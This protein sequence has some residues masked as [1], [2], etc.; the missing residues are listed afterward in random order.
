MPPVTH[1]ERVLPSQRKNE[2]EA[3]RDSRCERHANIANVERESLSAVGEWH[4]TF[5]GRVDTVRIEGRRLAASQVNEDFYPGNGYIH[6]EQVNRGSNASKLRLRRIAI[7]LIGDEERQSA[8]QQEDG[9]QRECGKQEVP[10]AKGI[11]GVYGRDGEEPIDHA[12]S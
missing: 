7:R 4:W 9:H 10:S 1:I 2:I 5:A 8:K 12:G 6:H 3:P 11:N